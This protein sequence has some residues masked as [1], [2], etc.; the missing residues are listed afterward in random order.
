MENSFNAAHLPSRGYRAA[1]TAQPHEALYNFRAT[2]PESSSP[3]PGEDT[4]SKS[5]SL[6]LSS[7]LGTSSRTLLLWQGIAVLLKGPRWG[8]ER[9]LPV[10]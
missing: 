6:A 4:S 9:A 2:A 8:W 3:R 10:G 5:R 1:T 7:T